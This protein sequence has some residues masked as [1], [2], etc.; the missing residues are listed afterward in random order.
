MIIYKITNTVNGMVYIGQTKGSLERR[1]SQHK[2]AVHKKWA[3]FKLQK[4]IEQFGAEAFTVE[5]ID[6]AETKEEANEKEMHWIKEY[7]SFEHGYNSSIGGNNCGCDKKVVNVET[8]EVY[9]SMSK[10][11]AA[12]GVTTWAIGQAIKNPTWKCAGFHWKLYE[13]Q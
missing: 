8:G 3:R 7:N 4:A 12:V 11:A 10:A 6:C 5:Q 9:G 1:W 2:A 13:K